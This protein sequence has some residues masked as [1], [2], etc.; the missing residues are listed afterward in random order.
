MT[1]R[2]VALVVEFDDDESL[3]AFQRGGTATEEALL[4]ATTA[5]MLVAAGRQLSESGARL[6]PRVF[7]CVQHPHAPYVNDMTVRGLHLR[8]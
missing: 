3:A 8:A 6:L 7:T 1:R 5:A 2:Y 4:E